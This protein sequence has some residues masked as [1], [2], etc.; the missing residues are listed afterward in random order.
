MY[1]FL[2]EEPKRCWYKTGPSPPA[3][4]NK[5]RYKLL[6]LKSIAIAPARTGKTNRSKN[7]AMNT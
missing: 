7:A 2:P 4:S 6:S 1:F 3:R 5:I